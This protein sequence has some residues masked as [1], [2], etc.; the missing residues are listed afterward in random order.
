MIIKAQNISL[1]I[2]NNRIEEILKG[3]RDF[4]ERDEI[5]YENKNATILSGLIDMHCHLREPGYEYKENIFSG[6]RS[7]IM[8]GLVGIC[9]MANTKPVNDNVEVL[10]KMIDRAENKI[11]FFP[12]CAIS[13][14]L[15]G[16]VLN[17]L[18]RL[19][20]FGAIAFSDDGKTLKNKELF[21]AALKTNHLIIS[22]VDDEENDI[23]WQ[24]DCLK[25]VGGRLHFAHISTKI[26]IN[27]IREAK[28]DKNLKL[29]CETAPHYFT[30][31]EE[32]VTK[33]GVFKMNPPL[34]TLE[35][36][37]A[38]IDGLKDGTI[39]VIATDHAPHSKLEKKRV[40]RNS[41]FGVVG[42][43]T[44]IGAVLNQFDVDLLDKK[45]HK[46]PREILGL[47]DFATIKVGNLANV[48][49][50]DEKLEWV[51]KASKFYSRC[52]ISPFDKM[53]LKGK[54]VASVVN[55]KFYDLT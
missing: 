31:T 52:K 26:A 37:L 12:I 34:R 19:K 10:S 39:D 49:I 11:G 29:T 4:L 20:E 24:M 8:G 36:K 6:V 44:V 47:G 45:M 17:D 30:F 32:D 2:K 5:V 22:H 40:F 38:V 46:N 7:A 25:E 41:P 53:V 21:K 33:N 54:P 3:Y 14:N 35:D 50:I 9:P 16:E 13:K 42:F 15:D 48:T 51:V 18:D 43:E 1:R 55:G 28:K 23:K 27:L